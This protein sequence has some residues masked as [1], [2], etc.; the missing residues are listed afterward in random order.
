[1]SELIKNIFEKRKLTKTPSFIAYITAGDPNFEMT[2]KIADTLIEAG[3]DILELGIP[4]SDPLADGEVNQLSAQRAL[5]SH[6]TVEDVLKISSEIKKRHKEIPIILYT[7]LNPV[8]FARNFDNFCKDACNSGV[9][10]LLLLDLTPEE[11]SEYKIIAEKN[12]LSIVALVT[13]NTKEKR[14]EKIA[15]FSS[16]FI[17]YVSQEGVTGERNDFATDAEENINKI[18]KHTN[19]PIAVGFGISKPEHVKA[20]SRCNVDGIVVGSAIVKKIENI[21]NAK[22]DLQDLKMFARS[23]IEVLHV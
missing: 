12:G 8:A 1:M 19:L 5:S 3:V 14:I 17:Y 13:P 11:G 4:F 9:D 6:T 7:Y 2:I 20:A 15:D 10:S 16:S 21:A 18:K 22:G 23:L